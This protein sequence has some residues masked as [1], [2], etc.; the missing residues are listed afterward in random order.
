MSLRD[1]ILN[2]FG[3]KLASAVV[4]TLIWITIDYNIQ[5]SFKLPEMH[6]SGSVTRR[7]SVLVIRPPSDMRGLLITPGEVDVTVRGES[8][9]LNSL[10]VSD[11][12]V[13]VNLTEVN[14]AKTFRKRVVV[15]TPPNVA[16]VK[17]E[18]E[19]VIVERV[20]PAESTNTH[21]NQN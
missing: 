6:A 9:V 5:N 8:W 16:V 1:R 15:N 4:A 18:P 14:D 2:H 20:S 17:V 7:L 21:R 13:F 11:V 3:W 12:Q 19:E 10:N